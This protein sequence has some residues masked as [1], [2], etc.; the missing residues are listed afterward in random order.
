MFAMLGVAMTV[1]T[2]NFGSPLL[3]ILRIFRSYINKN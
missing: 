1:S 2:A 3:A